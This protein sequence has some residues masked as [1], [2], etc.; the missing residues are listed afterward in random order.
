MMGRIPQLVS[1]A[2]LGF[3][4]TG[5]VAQ[6]KYNALKLER[7]RLV[8]QLG[9][10]D[11]DAQAARGEA[12]VY[13]N[14]F[15]SL[16]NKDQTQTAFVSN[17]QQQLA[18]LQQE[19]ADLNR[20][21]A[22]AI[23]RAGTAVA[24]PE[25]L[26]NALETFAQQNPGLV[27]F[28]SARGMVKFRSD[29]T[30]A[31]GSADLTDQARNAIMTFAGILNSPAARGYELMVA[32]HTDDQQVRN[33]ET[34]RRGH[35]DNWHLSAH[36]AISVSN[37]LQQQ[38]ISSSRIAVVGYADQRPIAQNVSAEGRQQNRRVEV[39]ILPTQVRATLA[40]GRE[41]GAAA[42]PASGGLNKDTPPAPPT[43]EVDTRTFENK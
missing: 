25:G 41:P 36:R 14:Q 42:T 31:T 15:G 35:L 18:Q 21:Y 24:L 26:N 20:R 23:N 27:D 8:E 39:L 43:A 34:I 7:D 4:L 3:T 11:R 16:A 33:P 40:G 13:R 38:G 10:A 12:E 5:C 28:D 22:D 2:L 29:V 37:T 32:G 30:F 19:N 1:F 9:Q 17:L 6:E